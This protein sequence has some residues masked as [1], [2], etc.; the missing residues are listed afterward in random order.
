MTDAHTT[1]G[2]ISSPVCVF[3]TCWAPEM[4]TVSYCYLGKERKQHVASKRWVHSYQKYRN[5]CYV[6]NTDKAMTFKI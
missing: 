3:L 2:K 6:N 4:H 1:C 5:I